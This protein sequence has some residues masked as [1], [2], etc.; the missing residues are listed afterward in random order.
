MGNLIGYFNDTW[1]DFRVFVRIYIT[2][3]KRIGGV[4]LRPHDSEFKS[5]L[6]Q[7]E[8]KPIETLIRMKDGYEVEK[9]PLYRVLLDET[10]GSKWRHV[11]II[12][13]G[14]IVPSKRKKNDNNHVSSCE[15]LTESQIKG[16]KDGKFWNDKFA[17]KVE[18]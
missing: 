5:W 2:E 6:D 4:E 11:L 17:V 1:R 18:D 8:N 7:A 3:I 15:L 10:E 12:D 13:N 14:K 9:E 16:Y